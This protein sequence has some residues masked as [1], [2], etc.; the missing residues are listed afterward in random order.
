M[1]KDIKEYLKR[2]STLIRR[3]EVRRTKEKVILEYIRI[4]E[5]TSEVMWEHERDSM[6]LNEFNKKKRKCFKYKKVDYIRRFYQSKENLS[7]EK[8]DTLTVFEKSENENVLKKKA[9]QNEKL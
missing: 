9:S 7:K 1:K 5:K 2:I 3:N 4:N 6:K 8:K